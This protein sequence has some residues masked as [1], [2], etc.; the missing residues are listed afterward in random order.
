M[1]EQQGPTVQHR[2]LYSASMRNYNGKKIKMNVYM[3]ITKSVC[4]TAKAGTTL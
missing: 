4:C 2:K 3:C 1:D